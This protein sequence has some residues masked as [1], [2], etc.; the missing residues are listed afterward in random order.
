MGL[1][2]TISR[3]ENSRLTRVE[4]AAAGDQGQRSSGGRRHDRDIGR[5]DELDVDDAEVVLAL[6]VVPDLDLVVDVELVQEA[7]DVAF[8]QGDHVAG[9]DR[10]A[11]GADQ[12]RQ[13]AVVDGHKRQGLPDRAAVGVVDD[14]ALLDRGVELDRRDGQP[15]GVTRREASVF[16]AVGGI[17]RGRQG[18]HRLHA[19]GTAVAGTTVGGHAGRG[20]RDERGLRSGCWRWHDH[21]R[22]RA[23]PLG[24]ALERDRGR[25]RHTAARRDTQFPERGVGQQQQ[26]QPNNDAAQPTHRL[27]LLLRGLRCSPK[28]RKSI[29]G[30]A[31]YAVGGYGSTQT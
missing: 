2:V 25:Q 14:A 4:R 18:R 17:G 19:T 8:A 13:I 15:H 24:R 7:E 31:R 12:R 22:R 3:S 21:Q 5:R 23:D 10:V 27:T 9:D 16:A 11:A 29:L 28:N 20:D 6:V 1:A 26:A 30:G